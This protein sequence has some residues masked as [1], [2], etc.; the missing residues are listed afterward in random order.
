MEA[1][2]VRADIYRAL[3]YDSS[4]EVKNETTKVL[5]GIDGIDEAEDTKTWKIRI[6]DDQGLNCLRKS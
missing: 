4:E 6:N 3:S 2:A 5:I 1:L